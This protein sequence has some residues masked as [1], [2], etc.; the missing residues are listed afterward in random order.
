MQKKSTAN[1]LPAEILGSAGVG[2]KRLEKRGLLFTIMKVT[3]IQVTVAMIFS[4]VS[5]AFENHAQEILKRKVSLELKDISLM[6]ALNEIEKAAKVKFV[7]SPARIN[8]D[9]K[10]S[11]DVSKQPLGELLTSLLTSREIKFKV[12]DGDDYI[13]LV[14]DEKVDRLSSSPQDPLRE[15]IIVAMISGTVSDAAG[16]PIPGVNI[17]VKGTTNGT[18][19]DTDGRYSLAVLEDNAILVFSFIG[20]VTEEVP[21]NGRSVIDISLA[22]EIQNLSE[23]VVIGY[24]SQKK[25][26]VTSAISKVENKFL[27]QIP[28]GRPESALIGRMAGVNI[29]QVRSSPGQEPT[30]TIRGPGSISASNS[31][32]IVIDGFPGGSFS[33]INMND[34]QSIE[35]LKDASAA[36]IYGSR[37]SGGVIIVTTK[38]GRSTKSQLNFNAY[39]GIAHPMVHGRDAWVS[40]GQEFYDYTA[41]YINRDFA[42]VG[43]DTSLPLWDDN[44][45][46]AKYRVNP[47][48]A[49]GNYNWE[50]ILLNPA[51]IQNYNLS[52][53]GISDNVNYYVSGT[54][55]DEEGTVKNTGFRQYALRANVSVDIN[56][57]IS[58]GVMIS[59]N[60]STRRMYPGG[61]QNYVKMPP[62]LSPEKQAD[63]TYLRPLDYWGT[64]VSAGVNPLATLE[65]THFYTNSFNN[66]GEMFAKVN[67]LKGLTFRSSLGINISYT[68]V[69]NFQEQQAS[70]NRRNRGNASDSRNIN[71]INENVLTYD[72]TFNDVHAFTGILGASYQ[73]HTSRFSWVGAVPGSFANETIWTLNNAIISPGATGTSKSQWGLSSY[74]SRVNYGFRDKYLLSASLRTD[75]SSRFGPDNRW[76]YFPSGSVAWRIS[77]EDFLRSL[78]AISELK[79]RASYGVVGNFNIGDFQY[80][81]AIGETFYSPDG[82]LVQGQAQSSFGNAGLKWEKTQSYDIG[83]ELGLF[84]N[85]VNLVVDY[86]DKLT[87]DLLYNV[88]IPAISGFTNTIVNIGDI[89]NKGIEVELNTKNLTGS[90]KWETSFNFSRNKNAVT[91]LGGGVDQVINTHSRGMG[92]LLRVGAPMFSYYGYRS[93]GVLM[94]AEDVANRP[95]IPGQVPGTVKYYDKNGDGTITPDDRMILGNFMPDYFMGMVNDFSWKNFDLSIVMQS[96]LGARMYNLENLYYQGPT[97]SAFLRPVVENQWWSESEPGDGKTPATSLAKLEYVGNSDYYL[98]DASF[99]A[100]RNANLGYTVPASVLK[101]WKLNSVRVYMSMSNALMVTAKG[102]NGYNP[103]GFTTR[104]ISGIKSQPGL[105]NGTEPINRTIALGLNLNF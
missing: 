66:I 21:V 12:Q 94:N 48:I 7:Y 89:S 47:V 5:I 3:L 54:L 34:I 25:S 19:T 95:I 68:T 88:S 27:D 100:I 8:L 41:R 50:D 85:R 4:G 52:F 67:I 97:V 18:T 58:A 84:N 20:Y 9:E 36:A 40:G 26:S 63:G 71:W 103:E 32:L 78:P 90:F 83:I 75:G 15:E 53:G 44:Q 1:D 46:P 72:K 102:F 93:A 101:R 31:P 104:G 22:E 42:W 39:Y 92:W 49:E 33:N 64:T 17:L 81:G 56:P 69:D 24:G 28:A 61:L 105:N 91:S 2:L 38:K 70:G 10:V 23:V 57:V 82:Q 99:F 14:E 11:L 30:I 51:P 43:G 87:R 79:V 59:P 86:Y 62:F 73:H 45:R 98:E 13:I 77:E 16:N 65:G 29:S 35:V 76:G 74:F 80:L 55:R 60:Y 96:S 37:G 6:H